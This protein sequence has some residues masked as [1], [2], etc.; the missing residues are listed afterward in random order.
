MKFFKLQ[1][2]FL[3]HTEKQMWIEN[4]IQYLDMPS[5]YIIPKFEAPVN[6]LCVI[7]EFL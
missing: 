1:S 6:I 4:A 7:N 3:A 2:Y 5:D